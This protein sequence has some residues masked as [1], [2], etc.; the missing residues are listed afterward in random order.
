MGYDAYCMCG[1]ATQDIALLN[2]IRKTCPELE[3]KE[4]VRGDSRDTFSAAHTHTSTPSHMHAQTKV[5][6]VEQ[7]QE[8]YVVRPPR[9]LTSQFE[10]RMKDK[11]QAQIEAE[12]RKRREEEE[13][14]IAVSWGRGRWCFVPKQWKTAE[15]QRPPFLL[16]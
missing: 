7:K 5:E 12:G 2:Q 1:Y 10:K 8:K 13:A 6:E 4:E 15:V 16:H 3:E 11:E 14:R 9:D